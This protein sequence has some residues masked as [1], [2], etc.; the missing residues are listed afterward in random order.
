MD[1]VVRKARSCY[2][3]FKNR[4]EGGKSWKNKESNK[5]GGNVKDKKLITLRILVRIIKGRSLEKEMHFHL[6]CIILAQKPHN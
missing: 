1:E 3:K 5:V 6:H 4:S 2:Q